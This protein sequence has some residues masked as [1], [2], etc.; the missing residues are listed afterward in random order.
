MASTHVDACSI[1]ALSRSRTRSLRGIRGKGRRYRCYGRYT[2]QV[3][4]PVYLI[5]VYPHYAAASTYHLLYLYISCRVSHEQRWIKH[6]RTCAHAHTKHTRHL[7]QAPAA[8]ATAALSGLSVSGA[9]DTTN[10]QVAP[11]PRAMPRRTDSCISHR[12]CASVPASQR[13]HL[14]M[15]LQRW[16]L[17]LWRW[18]ASGAAPAD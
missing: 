16:I 11:A 8:A 10:M 3:Y 15:D 5:V 6:F 9:G 4:R 18:E 2:Y 12:Q 14:P 1:A 13:T 17:V 7:A